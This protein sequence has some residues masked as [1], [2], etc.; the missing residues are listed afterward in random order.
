M[1][2][3]REMRQSDLAAVAELERKSFSVPW[4][5]KLLEDSFLS[6]LDQLWVVTEDE[7][8][9]GYCN[10]RVIAGEGELM[11]IA[12]RPEARGR[13][14]GRR[15]METLEGAA[16]A[17]GVEDIALEVRI[18]NKRAMDLYK[19]R[20]FRAE[21]VRKGYYTEPVEDAVIMWRRRS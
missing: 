11:R 18:S 6:P 13:G 3:V 15:L 2:T 21:A 14:Y 5:E 4:S 16:A 12:V 19:S 10:F 17:C 7:T 8:V 20:G 1:V 9:A